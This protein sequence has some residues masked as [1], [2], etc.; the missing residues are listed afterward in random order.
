MT[1][2]RNALKKREKVRGFPLRLP[3]AANHRMIAPKGPRTELDA[4]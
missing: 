2:P 1:V 3:G 4:R